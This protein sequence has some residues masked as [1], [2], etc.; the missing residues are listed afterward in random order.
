[1]A[2]QSKGALFGQ[3]AM[4]GIS[5]YLDMLMMQKMGLFGDQGSP[6]QQG[7]GLPPDR[8]IGPKLTPA[9]EAMGNPPMAPPR[10]RVQT[11]GGTQNSLFPKK[12]DDEDLYGVTSSL[13]FGLRRP[14]R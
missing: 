13:G 5:S 4:G 3:G 6:P 14:R 12:D 1:M 7:K 10:Q 8:M 9:V 2:R 11:F